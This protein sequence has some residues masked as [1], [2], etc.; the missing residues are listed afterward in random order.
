MASSFFYAEIFAF[1]WNFLAFVIFIEV[2]AKRAFYTLIIL[3]TV[4]ERVEFFCFFPL[5][6]VA[7]QFVARV[8][9]WTLSMLSGF[10]IRVSLNAS[11]LFIE[12]TAKR[13]LYANPIF[14]CVAIWIIYGGDYLF[15]ETGTFIG[16][17]SCVAG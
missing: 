1:I 3:E 14:E 13:A 11:L 4:T 17:E 9:R 12:K 7:F 16:L 15:G 10:A 5:A 6:F 8:A 2:V